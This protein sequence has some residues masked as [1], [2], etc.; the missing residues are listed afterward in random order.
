RPADRDLA[1]AAFRAAPLRGARRRPPP[2]AGREPD[3]PPGEHGGDRVPPGREP[4]A[5]HARSA[6]HPPRDPRGRFRLSRAGGRPGR[7]RGA[8]PPHRGG[9][10]APAARRLRRAAPL[11]PVDRG[12]GGTR[13]GVR[14]PSLHLLLLSGAPHAVPGGPLR[15]PRGARPRGGEGPLPP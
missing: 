12:A 2:A 4:V 8:L 14:D 13:G 7:L 1:P 11:P 6:S 10:R 9:A 3:P 5:A 15:A